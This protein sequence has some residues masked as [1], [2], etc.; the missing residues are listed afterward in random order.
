MSHNAN[1]K[2][3]LATPPQQKLARLGTNNKGSIRVS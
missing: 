2:E 3:I 1:V